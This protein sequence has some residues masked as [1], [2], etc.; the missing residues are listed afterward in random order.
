MKD[1]ESYKRA[2]AWDI[3]KLQ[4]KIALDVIPADL[5]PGG[6]ELGRKELE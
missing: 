3:T 4:E 6:T 1:F 2:H 5:S